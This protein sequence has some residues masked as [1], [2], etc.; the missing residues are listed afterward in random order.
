MSLHIRLIYDE[1]IGFEREGRQV[2]SR[3]SAGIG[4]SVLVVDVTGQEVHDLLLVV[5]AEM[6]KIVE[7][8]VMDAA[9]ADE[10]HGT[11][12]VDLVGTCTR[13]RV[14]LCIV[15]HDGA[16]GIAPCT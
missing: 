5:R 9:L 15:E 16:I 11:A 7:I 14:T 4:G 3:T 8:L 1:V 12:L 6:L 13:P 2:A 10:Q